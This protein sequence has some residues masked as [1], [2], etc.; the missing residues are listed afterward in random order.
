MPALTHCQICGR[1]I[2]ANTGLIA[3][4]GYR[5]PGAGWQTSSCMGARYRPYEVASDALPPAIASCASH[6]ARREAT[7]ADLL[8]SPPATLSYQRTDAWGRPQGTEH[9]FD[10]PADFNAMEHPTS[11]QQLSYVF[12]FDRR[13]TAI[14]RDITG[15]TESLVYLRKRLADWRA[16]A[17]AVAS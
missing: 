10:R 17:E 15:T 14:R 2:K 7:L 8:A 6:L 13:E 11:Y 3:H 5:R 1:S 4:H 16:P 12:Q 9:V